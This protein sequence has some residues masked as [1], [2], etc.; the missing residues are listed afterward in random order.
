MMKVVVLLSCM[1]EKDTSIV[2]RS[3]VQTDVVVVNQCD[4]NYTEEFDFKNKKGESCHCKYIN[5]TERG[6][7]RSRN[8]AI[9]N[10]WG[11]VCLICD[12]DEILADNYENLIQEG[13]SEFQDASVIAFSLIRKDCDRTYPT[14]KI[15][16]NYFGIFRVNSVQITFLRK[17]IQNKIFFDVQLGSG[18]G[19]GGGEENRFLL[20]CY[21]NNFKMYYHTNCIATVMPNPNGGSLWFTGYNADYI[22]KLGW[23]SRRIFGN[24]LGGIY[25]IYFVISHRKNYKDFISIKEAFMALLKGWRK[26][27][28]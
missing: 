23:S 26:S 11:D 21:N 10:S 16:I 3:S 13:Y 19:N 7:S 5:T 1:H 4:R 27:N 25:G 28:S 24:I 15:K 2:Q 22:E 14:K 9:Q 6:L 20:D 12:D 8:M 18:T 17:A